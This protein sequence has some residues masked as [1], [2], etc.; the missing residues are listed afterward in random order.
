MASTNIQTSAQAAE[1]LRAVAGPFTFAL[2]AAGIIGTGMLTVPVLAVRPAYAV[3][4]LFSWHVGLARRPHQAKSV[5]YGDYPGD[6]DAA[7]G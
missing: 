1:A 5:L 7:S 3:G 2:F 4:E 6:G